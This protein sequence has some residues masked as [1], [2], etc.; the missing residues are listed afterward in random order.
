MEQGVHRALAVKL[1]KEGDFSLGKS[2]KLAK[3][4]IA[5]FIEHVS[6]LGIPTVDFDEEELD[7]EMAFLNS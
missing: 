5:E 7:Q 3:M 2:A 4:S 6:Q 1:F